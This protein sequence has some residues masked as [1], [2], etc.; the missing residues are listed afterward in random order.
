MPSMKSLSLMVQEL[1]SML[2]LASLPRQTGQKLNAPESSIPGH[3]KK[4]FKCYHESKAAICFPC[5]Y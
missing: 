5:I 1:L 4:M 2:K 3:K